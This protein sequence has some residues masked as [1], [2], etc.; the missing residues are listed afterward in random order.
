MNEEAILIERV[1][2]ARAEVTWHEQG[3]DQAHK[4]VRERERAL[5]DYREE[6]GIETEDCC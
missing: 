5:R 4:V 1:E 2:R 6:H 3:L